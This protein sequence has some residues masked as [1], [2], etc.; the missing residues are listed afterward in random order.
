M[1]YVEENSD[2]GGV[3]LRGPGGVVVVS[4]FM[5]LLL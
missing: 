5:L 4:Y 2:I 1:R 3:Q